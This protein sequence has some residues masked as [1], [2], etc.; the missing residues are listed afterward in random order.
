MLLKTRWIAILM[1]AAVSSLRGC[2]LS[3]A[4]AIPDL[5]SSAVLDSIAQ[6]PANTPDA[7]IEIPVVPAQVLQK[8]NMPPPAAKP[9]PA[10]SKTHLKLGVEPGVNQIIPVAIRHLNRIVTPFSHPEVTTTSDAH[11]EVRASVVYVATEGETPVTLFVTEKEDENQALSL[12]LLPSRIPPREIVL[13]WANGAMRRGVNSLRKNLPAQRWE[14]GQPYISTVRT[15]F[16]K[17]ALGE[18]PP[19]YSLDQTGSASFETRC[20]QPGLVFDFEH[21]QQITGH[22]LQIQVGTVRNDTERAIVFEESACWRRDIAAVSAW[23]ARWLKPGQKT[24]IYVV[25]RIEEPASSNATRPSLLKA[26]R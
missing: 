25:K 16:R 19:G 21:G 20:Y 14:E 12:T 4:W 15:L 8:A 7:A 6:P 3:K 11:T 18:V 13:Q 24:E 9:L 2:G 5:P 10:L 1:I 17:I 26:L 22:H 23:P